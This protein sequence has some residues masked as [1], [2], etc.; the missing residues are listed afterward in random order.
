MK[1]EDS[2]L[3]KLELI[4]ERDKRLNAEAFHKAK[5]LLRIYRDVVWRTQEVMYDADAEAYDFGGRRIAELADYLSYDF[6]GEIDKENAESKLLSI[7][8]TKFLVDL[9]DKALLKL[10]AYPELGHLYFDILTKQ[11]INKTKYTDV[12]LIETISIERTQYY[13]RKKEAVN[14]FGVILWGY[15]IPP[16]RD[17]I[18]GSDRSYGEP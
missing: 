12:E 6:D 18:S 15:I 11:Y 1:E 4:V 7:A 9:V 10:N 2:P 17:Y 13:K 16:I 5:L 8:E 14:L 3:K